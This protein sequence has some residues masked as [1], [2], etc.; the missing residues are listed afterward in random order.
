M[1]QEMTFSEMSAFMLRL[2]GKMDTILR[3]IATKKAEVQLPEL[4]TLE[5]AAQ[6]LNRSKSTLY[7]MV[8]RLEIPHTKKGRRLTFKRSELYE[9]LEEGRR[10]TLSQQIEDSEAQMILA[11]S[12]K[13]VGK[14]DFFKAA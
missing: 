7:G 11:N 3:V 6:L 8:N 14:T 2:D 5:Q 10:K 9:W 13:V 4:L 12:K 1:A